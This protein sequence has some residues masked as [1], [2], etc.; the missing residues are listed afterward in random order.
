MDEHASAPQNP[1]GEQRT[2]ASIMF[3]D[4]VGFSKHSAIDEERTYR[5]LNRDFDLIYKAVADHN[6]QVLN[7]MG[8]GMMVVFM[9]AVQ[10]VQCAIA[11]QGELYR[12]A[13][14]KPEDGVLQHRLGLHVGDIILNGKNTMGDGVNQAARIQALARPESIAMSKE[15]HDMVVNKTPFKAKYL[16]PLRAKNIPDAIPIF[17]ISP[18]D[19][20]IRQ[21]AAEALFTPQTLDAPEGATGRR[22]AVILLAVLLLLAL[23]SAPVFLLKSAAKAAQE[24]AKQNGRGFKEG[25]STAE[26]IERIRKERFGNIKTDANAPVANNEPAA[27]NAPETPTTLSLNATEVAD[28]TSKTNTHDY[29]GVVEVLKKASGADSEDGKAMIK[30]YEDL[31]AFQTWLNA[32]IMTVTE[33]EPLNLTLDGVQVKV[34]SAQSGVIVDNAGVLTTRNLWEYKE[35]TILA[36]AEMLLTK[37]MSGN[38]VLAES[39]GWIAAF[40]DV[41][42]V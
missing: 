9:S 31:V 12:Q 17:E 3:T 42:K 23:A 7:T 2:L 35:S 10:C 37:T 25:K 1:Q 33:L 13:L 34:Y 20:E 6:G 11:I 5:A 26:E 40:K 22:S 27:N 41:H 36:I 8:D 39:R 28:V 14:S 24:Q 15:F 19:D 38:P 29:A 16:G 30:K 21:R 18:I 4:V 32:D